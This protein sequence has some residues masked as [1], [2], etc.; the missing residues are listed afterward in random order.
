MIVCVLSVGS[1]WREPNDGRPVVWNSSGVLDQ[2]RLRPRTKVFG[3]VRFNSRLYEEALG[4]SGLSG[5]YWHASPLTDHL[6]MRKLD[7]QR[8]VGGSSLPDCYLV[9]VTEQLVGT[10]DD[11]SWDPNDSLLVSFSEWK[12]RQEVLLLVGR[13]AWLRGG[14]GSAVL[15]PG[16]PEGDWNVSRW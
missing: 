14:L 13:H 10:L 6:G 9:S 11:R 4:T 15:T 1:C 7:L 16:A 5:S 8:R 2:R 3:Q 12:T